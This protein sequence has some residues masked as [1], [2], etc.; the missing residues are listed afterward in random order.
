MKNSTKKIVIAI[1]LLS[2]ASGIYRYFSGGENYDVF[3]PIFIGVVLA[4]SVFFDT[5]KSIQNK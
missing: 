3:F 2:I 5:S 1:G 4:G